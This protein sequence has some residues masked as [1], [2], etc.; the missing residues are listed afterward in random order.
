MS[1]LTTALQKLYVAYFNR[2]A[3]PDGLAYWGSVLNAGSANL[4]SVSAAFARSPE[5]QNIF[6]NLDATQIVTRIYHNL[7]ARAPDEIWLA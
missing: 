1:D 2:P 3:D 4:N 6:A 7:F 5:Y